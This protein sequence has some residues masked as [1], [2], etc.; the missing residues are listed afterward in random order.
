MARMRLVTDLLRLVSSR[1]CSAAPARCAARPPRMR[2]QVVVE[3]TPA[4]T[5]ALRR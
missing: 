5:P 4:P 2:R 1:L 3:P